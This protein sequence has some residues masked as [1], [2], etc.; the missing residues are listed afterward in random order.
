MQL[1]NEFECVSLDFKGF[2]LTELELEECT[3]FNES[4]LLFKTADTLIS[5]FKLRYNHINILK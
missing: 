4:A 2:N 3:L 1:L 5:D